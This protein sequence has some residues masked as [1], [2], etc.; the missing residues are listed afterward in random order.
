MPRAEIWRVLG[1]FAGAEYLKYSFTRGTEREV[2][3]LMA[4]L[5]LETGAR[6]L[7][8]GCGPGRHAYALARRGFEVVGVDISAGFVAAATAGAPPGATFVQA[9]AVEVGYDEEFDAVISL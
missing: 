7:D 4:L 3:A 5:D 9:D 1:D 2:E 6:I 8:V